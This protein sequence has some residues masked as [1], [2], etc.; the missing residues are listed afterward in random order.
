MLLTPVEI[1]GH[2]TLAG[3]QLVPPPALPAPPLAASS[4]ARV[5]SRIRF[6][7]NSASA[8]KMWKTSVPPGEVVSIASVMLWKPIP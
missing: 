2:S 8:P 6:R 1:D 3:I 5:R 7:S 4:P